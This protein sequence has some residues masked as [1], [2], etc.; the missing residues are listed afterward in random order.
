M[1]KRLLLFFVLCSCLVG[2]KSLWAESHTVNYYVNGFK[3]SSE[4]VEEG[5]A[6]EFPVDDLSIDDEF[7][8]VGWSTTE[9]TEPQDAVPTM[10]NSATMGNADINYYAV[11]AEPLN[12]RLTT[13]MIAKLNDREWGSDVASYFTDFSVGGRVYWRFKGM[14]NADVYGADKFCIGNLI[15][16]TAHDSYIGFKAPRAITKVTVG[17]VSYETE[18]SVKHTYSG[19]LYL[20]T[21]ANVTENQITVSNP[22]GSVAEFVPTVERDSFYLQASNGARIYSIK[23]TCGLT[24]YRTNIAD[25]TITIGESGYSTLCLPWHAAIPEGLTA[26]RLMELDLSKTSHQ[27]RFAEVAGMIA[28]QGYLI[29]GTPGESYVIRRVYSELEDPGLTNLMVGVADRTEWSTLI[30]DPLRPFILTN[31]GCFMQYTGQYI[32]ARK[33][34]VAVNPALIKY[35]AGAAE[36]RVALDSYDNYVTGL[37][38]ECI[39][40]HHAS[41]VVYDLTGKQVPQ[42]KRGGL[43]IVNGKSVLV[44]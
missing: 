6:L 39:E 19:F 18:T 44:K 37:S 41:P 14:K 7:E 22:S 8:L 42:I 9:L 10:V 38:E 27:L 12:Y 13:G 16:G 17:V 4:E 43:Y 24:G 15:G 29:K 30:S 33:A 5:T 25:H 34:F 23:I 1:M 36:L 40:T 2:T 26:Y 28:N 31:G 35:E 32:P 20:R 21:D 11:F 3:I